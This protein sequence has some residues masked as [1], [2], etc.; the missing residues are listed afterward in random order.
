T[1]DV[2]SANGVAPFRDAALSTD[3]VATILSTGTVVKGTV[4][5]V[6]EQVSV[7]VRLFDGN[8]GAKLDDRGFKLS[9]KNPMALRDSVV[10]SVAPLL[11]ERIGEE[12]RLRRQREGTDNVAAWT[13]V[14]QAAKGR[15][16]GEGSAAAGDTARARL[17]FHDADSLLRSAETLDLRWPEPMQQRAELALTRATTTNERL[18]AGPWIDSGF[19]LAGQILSKDSTNAA[20][21][22]ARGRL[23]YR[24]WELQLARDPRDATATLDGAV[25][26]LKSA[27]NLDPTRANAWSVLSAAYNQKDMFVEA[28]LAATRAYEEDAY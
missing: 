3:S 15:R 17:A 14:Q 9:A 21:L 28:K 25:E 11:R 19:A 5:G 13:L 2:I 16:D 27:T 26:D 6:G 18:L 12:L 10:G 24:R 20:A 7:V 4:E 22:E 23:R 8:S 1:L